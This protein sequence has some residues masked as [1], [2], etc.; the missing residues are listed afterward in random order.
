MRSLIPS[1]PSESASRVGAGGAYR[2]SAAEVRLRQI[3]SV[4]L[5]DPT[6]LGSGT[7]RKRCRRAPRADARGRRT[8]GLIGAI[9]PAAARRRARALYTALFNV[10]FNNRPP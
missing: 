10:G 5:F 8:R 4:N 2:D 1:A 3:Q 9:T 7:Y 6:F